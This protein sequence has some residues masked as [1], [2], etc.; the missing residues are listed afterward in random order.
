[1]EEDSARL[2]RR[3]FSSATACSS[4][5]R[6]SP[7]RCATRSPS[8]QVLLKAYFGCGIVCGLDLKD[9]AA[10]ARDGKQGRRRA[11][12][13]RRRRPGRSQFHPDRGEGRG[14]RLRRLPDRD[15]RCA[16]ARSHPR[17]LPPRAEEDQP[18]VH[19]RPARDGGGGG[20]R[21]GSAPAAAARPAASR[22]SNAPGCATMCWS[23]PSRRP[24]CRRSIC[25]ASPPPPKTASGG[26]APD[27]PAANGRQAPPPI[28]ACLKQ[29]G[30]CACCGEPWVLLGSVMVGEQGLGRIDRSGG[31]MSSRSPAPA[32]RWNRSVQSATRAGRTGS[33]SESWQ[34]QCKR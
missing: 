32:M 22:R 34:S 10:E 11:C 16:Q 23:R 33:E 6:T 5:P 20:A 3:R 15:L 21:S 29:C 9:P 17:S 14:A 13:S 31:D 28:C 25:W 4:P 2:D 12:P 26:A 30:E 24:A 27:Q 1:M 18:D 8:I 19:R 7:R